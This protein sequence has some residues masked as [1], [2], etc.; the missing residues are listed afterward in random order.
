MKLGFIGL[1]QMGKPMALNLLK[2]G[3]ELMVYSAV[4]SAYGELEKAG[5]QTI[6]QAQALAQ[7]D[8]IFLCLPNGDAVREVLFGSFALAQHLG[9][10][11]VVVDTSTIAHQ[12]T[13]DIAQS[14][15]NAGV[16]FMDAPVSGMEAR[17]IDGTLTIMCGGARSVFQIIE[18][19]LRHMGSNILFMGDVGSGQLTK[20][21]NQLLFDINCA[22]L[23]EVLPMAVKMGLNPEQVGEVVNSGTGKSYASDFF[24]PRILQNNFS[25]GYPMGSAYKDLISAA[26]LGTKHGIPMPVLAAAT[27]SYQTALLQGHGGKDKGAMILPF[28]T[29]LGVQFRH[30]TTEQQ[31]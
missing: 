20:L 4:T 18:P 28:E 12:T 3:A 9:P 16:S 13:L 11:K 25:S 30:N 5:A 27:T 7:A 19:L 23:A 1:G 17:A 8:V 10:G 6:S 24:I 2:S 21:I 14:L 26:Q 29:L 31:S 22:A 15:K